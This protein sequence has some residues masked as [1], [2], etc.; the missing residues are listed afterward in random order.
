MGL[1]GVARHA[2]PLIEEGVL[3][4]M[5]YSDKDTCDRFSMDVNNDF[6]V[7]SLV[8]NTGDGPS[9]FNE[10]V[11]SCKKPTIYIPFIHYMN[12]TNPA[13]G[14]CTGTSRFGTVLVE[15]GKVKN[16]LFNLRINDSYMR[17]FNNVEWLSKKMAHVNTSDTYGMRIASSIACPSFVK[18]NGV[19][20][21]D[22][23]APKEN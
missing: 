12:F 23:S 19:K 22:S 14:E 9:D 21:T 6:S 4:N 8:V 16:H 5:F 11:A 20:I 15:D 18:V 3:Q 17:I 1:N 7:S 2:F 10:M 13:K